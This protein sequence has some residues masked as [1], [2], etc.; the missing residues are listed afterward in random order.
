MTIFGCFQCARACAWHDPYG[1]C[2]LS[3][4]TSLRQVSV[5]QFY[6]KEHQD[7]QLL[8]TLSSQNLKRHLFSPGVNAV[9]I[10]PAQLAQKLRVLP[11]PGKAP[12]SIILAPS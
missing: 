6:R 7:S 9:S 2:I 11:F 3:T 12:S 5:T 1:Y 10:L 4:C 8:N